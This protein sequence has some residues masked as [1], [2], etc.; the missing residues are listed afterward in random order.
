VGYADVTFPYGAANA[1][2]LPLAGDWSANG[3]DTVG[4]FN[5]TTSAFFLRNTNDSGYADLTFAYGPAN[6]GWTPIVSDW[7]GSSGS[8]LR[9]AGG[10]TAAD[11]TAPPLTA[12]AL[13]PLA[14]E[15]IARWTAAG[16]SANLANALG[17]VQV[18]VTDLPGS[19]L[20]LATR[21]TVYIDRDAAGHGWFIDPTPAVD[22]EFSPPAS[23]RQLQAVAPQAMDQIDL[24]TVLEHELGHIAGL[25]D[26]DVLTDDVMSG[27]LGVGIRRNASHV[28]VALASLD[29]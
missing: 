3:T 28:D 19:M 9:A 25:S 29:S 11:T 1:G 5:P 27:V 4:L 8:P 18:V 22:E 20:G 10:A 26:L 12:S 16:V 21:T 6:A 23:N 2:W 15:S 13:Q 7:N 24:L 17:N 14:A